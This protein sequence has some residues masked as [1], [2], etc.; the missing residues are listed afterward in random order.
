[1]STS[2]TSNM[3]NATPPLIFS[4]LLCSVG[5]GETD[6]STEGNSTPTS[7][8]SDSDSTS[9]EESSDSA[10]TTG[11]GDPATGDGDG[12][13]TAG[14]GD[15]TTGDGDGDGDGDATTG[16]G[17]GDDMTGDGD[18]DACAL[19]NPG[20]GTTCSE[21][22]AEPF[23]DCDDLLGYGFVNGSCAP[24]EGCDCG[25]SCDA[26]FASV[27]KCASACTQAGECSADAF[28]GIPDWGLGSDCEVVV[29]CADPCGSQAILQSWF[30][31]IGCSVVGGNNAFCDEGQLRCAL[32]SPG[33][34][35]EGQYEALCGISLQPDEPKLWCTVVI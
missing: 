5:C 6:T 19:P 8:S 26:I 9:Q 32:E 13:P 25:D 12:D 27:N 30:P 21:I 33:V 16:D 35:S 34:I 18:G 15:A 29:F 1:M 23:G 2:T 4:L 31:G 17:D 22:G 28:V 3:L 7:G 20:A 24:I 11:D 10:P 14:D